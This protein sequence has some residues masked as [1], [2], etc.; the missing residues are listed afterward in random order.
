MKRSNMKMKVKSSLISAHLDRFPQE[1]R[2]VNQHIKS[3]GHSLGVFCLFL[4]PVGVTTFE[5]SAPIRVY[6][7]AK[8]NPLSKAESASQGRAGHS[9]FQWFPTQGNFASQEHSSVSG[10]IVGCHNWEGVCAIVI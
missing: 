7:L 6:A 8:Q 9:L 1:D 4:L 10:D 2:A 3:P 5:K